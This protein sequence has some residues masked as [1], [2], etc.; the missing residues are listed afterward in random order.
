MIE[1]CRFLQIVAYLSL[2]KIG[3]FRFFHHWRFFLKM[4]WFGRDW[5]I[6]WKNH[7]KLTLLCPSNHEKWSDFDKNR[8]EG[9]HYGLFQESVRIFGIASV[10][11]PI[12]SEEGRKNQVENEK[13]AVCFMAYISATKIAMEKRFSATER[14]WNF[15]EPLWKMLFR[16]I[17]AISVKNQAEK[18]PKLNIWKIEKSE[19][20]GNCWYHNNVHSY[21]KNDPIF[22]ISVKFPIDWWYILTL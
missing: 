16:K 4:K 17:N 18:W 13:N 2:V 8:R 20:H 9:W 1:T 3:G 10:V 14:K 21:E 11:W 12:L 7:S 5:S 22:L 6:F 15:E 19:V